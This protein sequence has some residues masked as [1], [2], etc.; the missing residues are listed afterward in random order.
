MAHN[1]N[2]MKEIYKTTHKQIAEVMPLFDHSRA[3]MRNNGNLTQWANGY[4]SRAQI[5]EDIQQGASYVVVEEGKIVGTFAFYLGRDPYY[6]VIEEGRWQDDTVPYGTIHR[7]ACAPGVHGIADACFDYCQRHAPTLRA[8]T[9]ADNT[10]VQHIL[11]RWGFEY[12]G[13]VHVGDGTPSKAYQRLLPSAVCEELNQWITNEIHPRYDLFDPAHQR[14]HVR[15][16]EEETLRLGTLYG[17]NPNL[18]LATAALHD[19]GLAHGRE[20]HHLHSGTFVRNEPTLL[21]WFSPQQ[22]ELIAQAV[23]DHRASADH[24]PRSLYG[25]IVAEAD[26][27][28]EPI[29]IVRRT[30]QYSIAHYPD[31]DKEQLCQRSLTHLHEKYGVGGYLKLYIPESRNAQALKELQL[32]IANEEA[33]RALFDQLLPEELGKA[34]KS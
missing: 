28:I 15:K 16:V 21:R 8:D 13:I 5:E 31:Y 12:C 7:L 11:T 26:R 24:E 27:D 4:P 30:L 25:K 23:E 18:L 29:K 34:R 3:I 19:V 1:S 10:I 32:L 9:H 20:E 6:A 17:L 14:D 2:G 22:I 33:L